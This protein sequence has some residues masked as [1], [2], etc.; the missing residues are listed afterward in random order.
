MSRVMEFSKTALIGGLLVILPVALIGLLL[1]KAMTVVE[2]LLGPIMSLLPQEVFLPRVIA[3]LII[4]GFCFLTGLIL[5]TRIGRLI[6][7]TGERRILERLPG[8]SLMRSLSRQIAGQEEGVSFSPA[9][10]EI[11]QALVPAFLVEEHEDGSYTVFVPASPTPTI[12][13]L[14][15]LPRERVHPVDVPFAKAVKC[16]GQWG[17]GSGELLR[18]MQ[19]PSSKA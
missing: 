9:L 14:Y 12:G 17:V 8:Y 7:L 10:V 2:K 18:A 19:R 1:L 11:E 13:S 15:I 3:L 5:K 16:V 6:Y 4:I